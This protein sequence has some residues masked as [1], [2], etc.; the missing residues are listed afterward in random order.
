MLGSLC[1]EISV[2]DISPRLKKI[3]S[4]GVTQGVPVLINGVGV[5]TLRQGARKVKF[6]KTSGPIRNPF[7]AR[8]SSAGIAPRKSI[9]EAMIKYHPKCTRAKWQSWLVTELRPF[10]S[11]QNILQKL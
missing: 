3:S 1:S 10:V 9:F 6:S 2:S 7:S 8:R 4:R 5:N 11:M